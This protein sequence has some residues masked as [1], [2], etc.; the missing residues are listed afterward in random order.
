MIRY[1]LLKIARSRRPQFAALCLVLFL[2]LMLVGF[3][4]YARSRTGGDVDFRY[5]FENESYFNGLTFSIYAFYFA[6]VLL[7]PIFAATEGGAQI[8]GETSARTMQLLLARPLSRGRLFALK[9]GLSAGYLALLVGAFLALTL[10]V[11]LVL[12]GWGELRLYPGVLQMVAERQRL[13]QG[14]A[15]ARFALAWPFASVA[16]TAPLAMSL[17]VS[18]W[19]RSAV[20]AVGT[21][22]A[23]YLVLYVVGE[24][25]FFAELRP[26]LFTSHLASWRGLFREEIDWASLLRDTAKASAFTCLF[27]GVALASFRRREE[28]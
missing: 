22:V 4:T 10:G 20:N 28:R 19:S 21:S 12:V 7:L 27:L 8:A 18:V 25:H 6:F 3:Y 23:L 26:Y 5:T 14:E 1:E 17:C 15:L 11:G 16:L 24:V 13:S 2:V 9:A